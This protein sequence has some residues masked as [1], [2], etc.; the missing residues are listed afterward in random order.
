MVDIFF[1]WYTSSDDID[2]DLKTLNKESDQ[3]N[4][5]SM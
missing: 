3:F 2:D 4:I 1:F 5:M